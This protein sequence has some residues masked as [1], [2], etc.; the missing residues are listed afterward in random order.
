MERGGFVCQ[1]GIMWDSNNA[2]KEGW[3]YKESRWV[4]QWRRRYFI[5]HG[6]QLF[7]SSSKGN[8]PHGMAELADCTA[9]QLETT[10]GRPHAL[11]IVLK[12]ERFVLAADSG[13]EINAW[14]KSIALAVEKTSSI[15]EF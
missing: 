2:E 1:R 11:E 10:K 15:E 7:W 5:L 12:D 6:S 4:Q 13:E 14:L 8:T 9:K 3:L